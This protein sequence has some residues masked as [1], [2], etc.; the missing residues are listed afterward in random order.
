MHDRFVVISEAV[1]LADQAARAFRIVSDIPPVVTEIRGRQRR[2]PHV[3][4][5][6]VRRS[7]LNVVPVDSDKIV[8]VR[9]LVF[10]PHPEQMH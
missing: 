10:V 3:L 6:V 2:V 1:V 8:S 4:E 9:S 5:K 7:G